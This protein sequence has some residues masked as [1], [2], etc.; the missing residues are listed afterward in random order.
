MLNYKDLGLLHALV[1]TIPDSYKWGVKLL[2]GL[3]G[4]IAMG[5][6]E[7]EL[8]LDYARK[9]GDFLFAEES[10]VFYA[11]LLLHLDNEE[12]AAW[13]TIS[14]AGLDPRNNL[15]HCFVMA[16]IAMR[17]G[18]NDKAIEI[19]QQRPAGKD[20][21]PFYY[22]DFM[23]GN[24]KLRRLDKDAHQPLERYVQRFDGRN[25][26]KEGYQKLAWHSL[27]HGNEAGYRQYMNACFRHGDMVVDSD[28]SAQLEAEEK[29]LPDISLLK[30][31][32]LFDG[33]YYQKAYQVLAGKSLSD[34]GNG[35][36]KLEFLYRMGRI[37]HGLGQMPQALHFYQLTIDRGRAKSYF[38]ACNAALQAGL[39]YEKMGFEDMAIRY[40][41]E[42]LSLYPDEYRT[43]LHQKAKSGLARMHREDN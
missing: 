32:L 30:A 16:N 5:R 33:G 3:E 13:Q 29:N 26:I 35:H 41:E 4:S 19:L 42:C 24:A 10:L 22:L 36:A 7:L 21:F 23:L 25:F 40:F 14:S 43:G 28:K 31:R 17:T 18:R 9:D 2:S 15:L 20:F 12:E 34:F 1:G 6:R 37:L 8:T 27:V 39:I 38:F 11:F